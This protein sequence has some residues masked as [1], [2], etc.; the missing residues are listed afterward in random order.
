MSVMGGYISAN[1]VNIDVSILYTYPS[2]PVLDERT[3]N[4]SIT[5]GE[6]QQSMRGP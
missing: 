2:V 4:V 1:K 3:P 6:L 5:Y